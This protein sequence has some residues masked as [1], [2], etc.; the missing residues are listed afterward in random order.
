MIKTYEDV[1]KM[2]P[3]TLLM[4]M[5]TIAMIS[6]NSMEHALNIKIQVP[7]VVSVLLLVIYHRRLNLVCH[8]GHLS[9]LWE[10]GNIHQT[11]NW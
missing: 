10:Q 6:E 2:K 11:M 4:G 7:W 5:E 3:H 9:M 8:D 1:E